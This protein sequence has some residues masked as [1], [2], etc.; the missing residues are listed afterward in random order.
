MGSVQAISELAGQ[1]N[2]LRSEM[3]FVDPSDEA[4]VLSFHTQAEEIVDGLLKKGE[5]LGR[6]ITFLKGEQKVIEAE[7][8]EWK[9]VAQKTANRARA[10]EATIKWL[11]ENP[12]RTVIETSG[13]P[14]LSD[15]RKF[16]V[17]KA[18]PSYRGPG[19]DEANPPLSV[20]H[21]LELQE[22]EGPVAAAAERIVQQYMVTPEPYIDWA[23]VK[24]RMKEIRRIL[25]DPKL[26]EN[27]TH[28]DLH[29]MQDEWDQLVPWVTCTQGDYVRMY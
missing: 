14:L 19:D 2:Q 6:Y 9:A 4:S 10:V 22:E 12:I 13:R 7:A 26:Q 18:P 16:Q 17:V 27:Y 28:E 29:A 5:G 15:T 3:V 11:M 21:M 20:G 25:T 8:D 24:T 1:L 23:A